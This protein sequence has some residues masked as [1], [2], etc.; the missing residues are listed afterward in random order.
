[1][2]V[3]AVML[4]KDEADVIEPVVRHTLGQVDFAI[5]ADN[6]STDGTREILEG[7][8][9]TI[10]DDPEIAYQQS[11]K[12]SALAE[13][14]RAAGAEWVVPVDGDELWYAR[15]GRLGDVLAS[16]PDEVMLAQAILYDH[17]ATGKDRGENPIRRMAWRKPL[18]NSLTKVACRCREGL[19]IQPG[20]HTASYPDVD[21]PPAALDLLVV[22]HF[23]Y[24]S[25][26]QF[27][28]RI[29]NGAAAYAATDDTVPEDAG[30]HKRAF[31][32]ILDEQ[33]EAA[34]RQIFERDFFIADP[35]AE[36]LIRDPLVR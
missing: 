20:N 27:I 6:G 32:K 11:R 24:R 28:T 33:G 26:D 34:L 16:L 7:F 18:S 19:V 25:A 12:M 22:H 9:V 21:V 31:G 15:G 5:V 23:P 13:K 3:A 1:M 10:V 29:R 30:G 8:D 4:V 35:V 14:A 2:S 36:G 17:I